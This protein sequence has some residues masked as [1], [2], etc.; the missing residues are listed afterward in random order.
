[1]II[2]TNK[3]VSAVLM[4]GSSKISKITGASIT[5]DKM[6]VEIYEYL[7]CR[8]EMKLAM[9][10]TIASLAISPGC[11]SNPPRL[12]QRRAPKFSVPTTST[13]ASAATVRPYKNRERLPR[14]W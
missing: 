9:T 4:F 10:T 11:R 3:M 6:M 13:S 14:S 7:P 2:H 5:P 1:M 12:N 8:L